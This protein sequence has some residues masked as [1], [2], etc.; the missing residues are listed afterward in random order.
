[1]RP[2]V[3]PHAPGAAGHVVAH[4]Q[5]VHARIERTLARDP[6]RHEGVEVLDAPP[7]Q[8]RP[9]RL[10]NERG[11][12]DGAGQGD[13]SPVLGLVRVFQQWLGEVQQHL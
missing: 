3:Q 4:D 11:V 7:G 5:A 12:P 8:H 9:A 2:H 10:G 6:R 13:G 1:M